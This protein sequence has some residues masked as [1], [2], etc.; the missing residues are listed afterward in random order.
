MSEQPDRNVRAA[1]TGYFD[2]QAERLLKNRHQSLI[3]I[4]SDSIHDLRVAAKRMR[5]LLSLIQWIDG[6]FDARAIFR[7]VRKLFKAAGPVRDIHV[8]L[9]ICRSE[10]ATMKLELSEYINY[11]IEEELKSRDKYLRRADAFDVAALSHTRGTFSKVLEDSPDN[12]L[13]FRIDQRLAD[14]LSEITSLIG[15]SRLTDDQRHHIRIS[16]K[17]IRYTLEV[18]RLCPNPAPDLQAMNDRLRSCH[19]ALG[20]WHD[21][22]IARARLLD[23]LRNDVARPLIGADDFVAFARH[24]Q[25]REEDQL[26]DFDI[27]W[28]Q[29]CDLILKDQHHSE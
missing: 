27:A 24:L 5:A 6:R 17:A 16:T 23:Y 22:L 13:L 4:T 8:Q 2:D 18:R 1:I 19:Q 3:A 14:Q 25:Q 28:R 7:P 29:L 21:F 26:R 20:L 11:L 15:H 10:S 9:D 12:E